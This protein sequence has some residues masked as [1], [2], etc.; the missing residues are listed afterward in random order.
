MI[1]TFDEIP[2]Q[3]IAGFKG[4]EGSFRT[5]LFSDETG[6]KFMKGHLDPGCSI[7]YHVHEGNCEV[8]FVLSGEGS[9]LFDG[10]EHPLRAGQCHCCPE[11]H[12]HSLRGGGA[13]GITF[14]ACVI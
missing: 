9:V 5:R 4:G 10:E 6:S 7:G 2:E 13:E 8:V 1:L 11:G 12:S 14:Y 3:A